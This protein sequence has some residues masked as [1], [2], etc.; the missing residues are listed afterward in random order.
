MSTHSVIKGTNQAWKLYLCFAVCMIGGAM[1]L[2]GVFEIQG[3]SDQTVSFLPLGC[4]ITLIGT[5]LSCL[6]IRCPECRYSWVWHA[7]TKEKHNQWVLWLIFFSKCPKCNFG[8][9][10]EEIKQKSLWTDTTK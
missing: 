8:S 6:S 2:Y 9:N 10:T 1:M 5:V 3:N 4:L 7:I